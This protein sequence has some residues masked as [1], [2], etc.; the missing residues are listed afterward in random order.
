MTTT[1]VGVIVELREDKGQVVMMGWRVEER[2]SKA[3]CFLW[4]GGMWVKSN[5]GERKC[6]L[7]TY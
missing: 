2:G 5:I 7:I 4:E 3:T 1:R 6:A